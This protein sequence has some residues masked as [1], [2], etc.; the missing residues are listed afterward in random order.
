MSVSPGFRDFVL[1]Q[2]ARVAPGVTGRAM[3]GGLGIYAQERIFALVDDDVLYLKVDDSNRGDF[4]AAGMGPF[5]PFGPEGE[6][7]QY[8]QLPEGVLDDAEALGP[9]VAKAVAVAQRS[10]RRKPGSGRARGGA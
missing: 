2:L 7:M 6:V 5:R 9:W 3:F 1:E 10:R 8:W 4:E